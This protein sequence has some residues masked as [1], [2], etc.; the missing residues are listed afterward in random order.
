MTSFNF[1]PNSARIQLAQDRLAAAYSRTPG[2]TVPIVEPTPVSPLFR[3]SEQ[4][5]LADFDKMMEDSVNWANALATCDQDW[6][7]FINTFCTVA[8]VPEA[9]GCKVGFAE[10]GV[11]WASP[12][13][14]DLSLVSS[15][16]P[17]KPSDS[18]MIKRM[19]DWIDLA[20]RKLGSE[21]PIWIA[22]I[23]SPF[24][25]AA[26]IV[27][28]E[29]L[30]MGCY[31]D[32]EAVHQ[33]CRMITDYSIE[34]MQQHLAL[35]DHACF[36]GRN[37]PS[38]STDIGICI[39]DDTPL[40]MLSPEMYR[41]FALPYNAELGA[42]FGGIHFHSCGDYRNNLPNLL[43]TPG[44]RSIQA[45]VGPGEFPLPDSSDDDVPFNHAREQ[46]CYFLDNGGIARGDEYAGR[47][48]DHYQDY[49][50]PRLAGKNT[51]GLIIQNCGYGGQFKN[52]AESLSWTRDKITALTNS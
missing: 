8:M 31:T 7:P 13:I 9:F 48:R 40:V 1:D 23:Q 35:I 21:V 2:T 51:T 52:S 38:I 15:L 6:P 47:E 14:G 27:D 18:P 24:S 50:L 5:K 30:L 43:A 19:A 37:F 3:Y 39:A 26:Q 28:H 25:V 11:A 29:E 49:V 4:E 22:D 45:H 17:L 33:L 41:E 32:P 12:V 10:G 20:Q 36:P 34:M 46:V 44:I 16:K 42:A